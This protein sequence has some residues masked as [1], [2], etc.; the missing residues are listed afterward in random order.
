MTKMERIF[1]RSKEHVITKTRLYD[2]PCAGHCPVVYT[3]LYN[4]SVFGLEK[5][6]IFDAKKWSNISKYLVGSGKMS[7]MSMIQPRE[8]ISDDLLIVHKSEY[9]DGLRS[10]GKLARILEIFPVI[11][12]PYWLIDRCV[13]K[14][15]RYQTGGSIL[16]A[17]LAIDRGWAIN[18]GGGFHHACATEGG[19]FCV[20]ADIT[21]TLQFLFLKKVISKAMIIDLDAHQGNGHENDFMHDTRVYIFDMFNDQIYPNDVQAIEY[22]ENNSSR[23]KMVRLRSWTY[24][25]EYIERLNS[26]LYESFQGFSADLIVYNAGTDLLQGDPLGKLSVS[27][28]AVLQRDEIVFKLAKQ[29]EIP[30]LMLT[31][32]GYTRASAR[33]IADSI[34]NLNDKNL[35]NLV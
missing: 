3:D 31:S 7:K 6:H 5:L 24:D 1:N 21:L 29:Y 23:G 18:I 8:A 20:Y 14:P 35:I 15:M 10:F 2:V 17:K 4:I 25:T 26:E 27:P 13:L 34:I 19:G 9:L 32:G 28:E 30:I 22:Y 33:I 12:L 16:A 11:F